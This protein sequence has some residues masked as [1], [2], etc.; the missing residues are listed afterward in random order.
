MRDPRDS[1]TRWLHALLSPFL[2]TPSA[3]DEWPRDQIG[4]RPQAS[5]AD[6][7]RRATAFL[8]ERRQA[9]QDQLTGS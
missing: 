5:A 6:A 4:P 7:R 3:S 2:V 8:D 1:L 9:I